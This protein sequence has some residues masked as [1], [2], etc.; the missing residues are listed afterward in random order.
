MAKK[1]AKKA[2]KGG[3]AKKS[4]HRAKFAKIA[5]ACHI[6]VKSTLGAAPN[7][8]RMKAVGACVKREFKKDK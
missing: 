5:K 2:S 6:E 3:G 7:A 4:G 1:A 8:K